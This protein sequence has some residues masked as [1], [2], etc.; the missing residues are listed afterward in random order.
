METDALSLGTFNDPPFRRRSHR[1]SRLAPGRRPP[2]LRTLSSATIATHDGTGSTCF[3]AN[4]T[5]TFAVR[6]F[7]QYQEIGLPARITGFRRAADGAAIATGIIDIQRKEV[8][9]END[10]AWRINTLIDFALGKFPVIASTASDPAAQE[11]ITAVINAI[12]EAS[13]GLALLQ[14][15]LLQGSVSGMRMDSHPAHACSP[16][17][18]R[19]ARCQ[20]LNP[21]QTIFSLERRR[22]SPNPTTA[23]GRGRN[24]RRGQCVHSR[25]DRRAAT[26]ARVA[27]NGFGLKSSRRS[28]SARCRMGE[29]R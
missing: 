26:V 19:Q 23:A 3:P 10:I 5:T 29:S 20:D 27:I 15:I 6:P 28:V 17:T 8:V 13:G 21:T 1:S 9:I 2:A 24:R 16:P 12:L 25:P 4:N 14:Q 18:P 7:R 11:K 22:G